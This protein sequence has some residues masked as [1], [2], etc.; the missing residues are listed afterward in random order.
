MKS[1]ISNPVWA[2]QHALSFEPPHNLVHLLHATT[3]NVKT[4][5]HIL[6]RL[7]SKLMPRA[8][9]TILQSNVDLLQ[10]WVTAVLERTSTSSPCC[11]VWVKAVEVHPPHLS[12]H[13]ER[14]VAHAEHLAESHKISKEAYN[15]A[16]N[17]VVEVDH[18]R[19]R[20]KTAQTRKLHYLE[21]YNACSRI[22][23]HELEVSRYVENVPDVWY[24][25]PSTFDVLAKGKLLKRINVFLNLIWYTTKTPSL[26]ASEASNDTNCPIEIRS[27]VDPDAFRP[28]VRAK[29][30]SDARY[31]S[32]RS[33]G[34]RQR[35][36]H[37]TPNTFYQTSTV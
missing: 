33:T 36:G 15:H 24:L 22:S 5:Y 23:G 3:R 11:I 10:A 21:Q 9:I 25:H 30:R 37:H 6:W 18:L 13:S 14:R 1:D 28:S 17:N 19:L 20:Y 7:P 2:W 26:Q 4:D 16:K 29:D 35:V 32:G 34:E 31:L 12:H 8:E 27:I